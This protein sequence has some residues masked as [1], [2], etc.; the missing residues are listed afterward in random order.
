MSEVK[1]YSTNEEMLAIIEKEM[2]KA[3]YEITDENRERAIK[4]F[5]N[6]CDVIYDEVYHE[7]RWWT[8]IFRVV[9]IDIDLPLVGFMHA[10]RNGDE[11]P[12]DKGWKFD[13]G[14]ITPVESY[15]VTVTKYRKPN[16][17]EE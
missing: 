2:V 4:Q 12:R 17:E 7:A 1:K 14:T 16:Q 11:S 9:N 8:E 15:E 13:L 3:G 5:L 10:K 6:D